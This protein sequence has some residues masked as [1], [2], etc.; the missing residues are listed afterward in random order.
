MS[1]ASDQAAVATT[2]YDLT[3]GNSLLARKGPPGRWGAVVFPADGRTAVVAQAADGGSR[4]SW[5]EMPSGQ[6][7]G[8]L[9]LKG[10]RLHTITR[11]TGGATL[12]AGGAEQVLVL[13]PAGRRVTRSFPVPPA[14]TLAVSRDGLVATGHSDRLIRLFELASGKEVGKLGVSNHPLRSL[15]FSPDGRRLLSTDGQVIK[16]WSVANGHELL[17]FRDHL[18]TVDQVAWSPGGR[19]IASVSWD[20]T[21]R[22]WEAAGPTP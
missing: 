18:R 1:P 12:V 21:L 3:T 4:L 5:W 2:F 9:E 8:A 15:A 6:E 10:V 22:V 13:D 16:V 11:T 20:H 17:T 19:K 14:E 7:R